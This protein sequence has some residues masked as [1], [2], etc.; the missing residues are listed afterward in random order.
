MSGHVTEICVIFL[1]EYT[2]MN[3]ITTLCVVNI[4]G[5]QLRFNAFSNS[6]LIT[7]G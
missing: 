7:H 4:S 3:A 1:K 2:E 5:K 6:F